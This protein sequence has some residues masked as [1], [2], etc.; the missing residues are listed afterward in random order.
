MRKKKIDEL[1]EQDKA[2]IRTVHANKDLSWDQRLSMLILRFKKSERTIRR[3]IR[4][5]GYNERKEVENEEIREGLNRKY[6]LKKKY[7]L[8][9]WAQNATPVHTSFWNNLLKYAEFLNAD[10]G[11]IQGRYQNPTSLWTKNMQGDEWWDPITRPYW[12]GA[13]HKIHEYLTLASDVK[14]VP[15]AA[16]PLTGFESLT[17][18]SSCILGHPRVHMQCLPVPEGHNEKIL[19]TTGA[20][21]IKNYTDTK[22]GK[23]GEFHHT[24][25]F[26]I[27]EIQDDLI[28]HTRQV[29]AKQDG[30]FMDL[31]F[32]VDGEVTKMDDC[33]A[34]IPGDIHVSQC[35][36]PVMEKT[37][38]MF[39]I[40]KPKRLLL[41]DLF[42]GK[43]ISHHEVK[44]PI[45]LYQ[46]Y[47]QGIDIV[48][49]EVDGIYEFIDKYNLLEYNPII[50]RSNH[51]EWL[52]RWVKDADW[53][54][55]IANAKEYI[56]W[57]YA[58][59][60]GDAPKGIFPYLINKRYGDKIIT[61]DFDDSFKIKGWET[62]SHGHL[63][64]NGSK[65][66]IN[67]SKKFNVK[68]IEADSHTAGRKDGAVRVGTYT[69]KRMGFNRGPSSWT[70]CGAIIHNNGKCQQ[71]IFQEDNNF[72][73]LF[74]K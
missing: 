29:T 5:L 27:I 51:D 40:L 8:I 68:M 9:T 74:N 63:G 33:E 67:Q 30:S 39:N 37:L 70:W 13:R 34:F 71:I 62:G 60:N 69:V 10:I 4:D 56:E 23:K 18:E 11:V 58:L 26:V 41:H 53:K 12:D 72:T 6:D 52:D 19:F 66:G 25:G 21:T 36:L 31:W 20:C 50:V 32:S 2:Y 17:G 61:L 22:A 47:E 46:K 1:T 73:T 49:K 44:D 45:K 64:A 55:N 48:R 35:H 24:Y 28:C 38:E 7:F 3:W 59:L 15:T 16:D 54:K 65:G 43:S 14:I 57:T 42:N